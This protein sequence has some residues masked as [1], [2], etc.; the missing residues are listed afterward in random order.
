MRIVG[1]LARF[2]S[3]GWEGYVLP[4][5]GGVPSKTGGGY[6]Y[7]IL[8][9]LKH[10]HIVFYI[11]IRNPQDVHSQLFHIFVTHGFPRQ[12][13]GLPRNDIGGFNEY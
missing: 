11:F 10:F 12:P 13:F 8:S 1:T 7:Y 5:Y 2:P 6:Q 9:K 4:Q 3:A